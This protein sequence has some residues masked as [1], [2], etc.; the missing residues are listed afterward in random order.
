M[1]VCDFDGRLRR[2]F[3]RTREPECVG[4]GR[5]QLDMHRADGHEYLRINRP[6]VVRHFEREAV[7]PRRCVLVVLRQVRMH[8]VPGMVRGHVVVKMHVHERREQGCPLNGCRR[9]DRDEFAGQPRHSTGYHDLV[10]PLIVRTTHW[11]NA[12]GFAGL[13]VSGIAILLAHPRLYWGETG[14]V[15]A[16]SLVDVPLPFVFG[17]SGWGRSLHFASGWLCVLSGLVYVGG[18]ALT[19]HFTGGFATYSPIRRLTYVA[20][21]FLLFPMMLWTGLAMSPAITSAIPGLVT[22]LGGQQTARTMH[23]GLATLL[24]LFAAG[25]IVMVW[26]HSRAAR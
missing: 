22:I 26:L 20:I 10:Q 18:A 4:H 7:V 2:T 21:V 24:V 25:H 11:T 19:H 15:G 1:S 5:G 9:C 8:R 3:G 6:V 12:I 14:T 23:F 13:V 17:H 16:A